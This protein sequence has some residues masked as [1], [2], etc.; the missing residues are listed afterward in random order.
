MST[1]TGT[2]KKGLRCKNPVTRGETYCHLH[3][4]KGGSGVRP[5]GGSGVKK[6]PSPKGVGVRK[7]PSPIHIRAFA[8]LEKE[9]VDKRVLSQAARFTQRLPKTAPMDWEDAARRNPTKALAIAI[10]ERNF[11]LIPKL[12]ALGGDINDDN[13]LERA[14]RENDF[15]MVKILVDNGADIHAEYDAAVKTAGRE[16]HLEILHFF[17]ER[18]PDYYRR[19]GG[20]DLLMESC[21]VA[22]NVEMVKYLLDH[23]IYNLARDDGAAVDHAAESGYFNI[24]KLLIERGADPNDAIVSAAFSGNIDLVKYLLALPGID[25]SRD[26]DAALCMASRNDRIE[27]VRALL[28]AGAN[29]NAQDD[30]PL[31]FALRANVS[32]ELIELLLERGADPRVR[33]WEAVKIAITLKRDDVVK[34]L[35]AAARRLD[36]K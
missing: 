23:H 17:L 31:R 28:D 30:L 29:V 35:R 26:D 9:R 36:H 27:V 12:V 33:N 18:E 4:P 22:R 24:V 10:R 15:K 6:N 34:I 11:A 8:F 25:I 1:C 21:I 16:E 13:Y 7:S 3:R 20:F 32:K 2:T 5:K 14:V 19:H